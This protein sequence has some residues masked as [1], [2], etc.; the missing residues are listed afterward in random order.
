M[1]ICYPIQSY[2]IH[3]CSFIKGV[4]DVHYISSTEPS[5]FLGFTKVVDN[6]HFYPV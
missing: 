5:Y 2:H 1:P 6:V 3:W 4:E